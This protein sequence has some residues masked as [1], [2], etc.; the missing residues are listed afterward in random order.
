MDRDQMREGWPKG[1]T[2]LK[3]QMGV[4]DNEESDQ[5]YPQT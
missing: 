3:V 1:K 5:R 4:R 2:S